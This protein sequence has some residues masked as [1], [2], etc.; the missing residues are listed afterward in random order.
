MCSTCSMR[1]GFFPA[2][3][4]PCK[5]YAMA[6]THMAGHNCHPGLQTACSL[7]GD[8]VNKKRGSTGK[9]QCR[10]L[11]NQNSPHAFP[12]TSTTTPVCRLCVPTAVGEAL[13]PCGTGGEDSH[14]LMVPMYLGE[15]HPKTH[16]SC[17]AHH[18]TRC[19]LVQTQPQTPVLVPKPNPSVLCILCILY[20]PQ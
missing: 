1:G 15:D 7:D 3:W 8:C 17:L 4:G 13:G 9:W 16:V 5:R 12:H 10:N 19:T 6:P 20:F 11:H 18:E 2:V 14:S